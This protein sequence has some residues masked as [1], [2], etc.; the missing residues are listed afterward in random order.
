M[1]YELLNTITRNATFTANED[2]SIKA[3]GVI[4]QIIIVGSPTGKFIQTDQVPAFNIPAKT[5]SE[6][7][8]AYINTQAQAYVTKTYPNS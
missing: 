1:T 4:A 2:G 6:E 8:P 5:T 3:T 7:Q